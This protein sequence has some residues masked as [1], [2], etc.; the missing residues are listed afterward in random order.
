MLANKDKTRIIYKAGFG[1]T[2]AQE[3]LLKTIEF[4]LDNPK[5]RGVFVMSFKHKKPFILNDI[6]EDE[7]RL[8]KRSLL[9]AQQLG[10]Q[11]LVCVPILYEN[12]SLGILAVDNIESKRPSTKSDINL[13]LGVASQTAISIINAHSFQ[14]TRDSEK[15]YRDLVENANS[16]IMRHDIDGTITFFNEFAQKLFRYTV[17]YQFANEITPRT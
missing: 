16:I 17:Q 15:K 11:S 6:K 13:L 2:D 14:K 12:E 7:K 9:L 8:S 10:V 5:S 3:R 4:H 1:Y